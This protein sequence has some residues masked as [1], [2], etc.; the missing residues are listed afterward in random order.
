MSKKI[1]KPLFVAIAFFGL[2]VAGTA[3]AES[4]TATATSETG[5]YSYRFADEDLLGGTLANQ[6]DM[7]RGRPRFAR[8]LLLRP[9]VTLVAE[10]LK[11]AEAL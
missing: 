3:R 7:F 9:R 1:Q 2:C 11:S 4:T 8:V 6:G 10:L 5:D